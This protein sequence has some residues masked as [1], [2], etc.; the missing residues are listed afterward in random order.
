MKIRVNQLEEQLG[1]K[2]FPA[3]ILSGEEPF[4]K[5]EASQKIRSY[6]RKAGFAERLVYH[7]DASFKWG[8][9][10]ESASA[11]SLFSDRSLI[12]VR[13]PA[14]YNFL[15]DAESALSFYAKHL[16]ENNILLIMMD[17]L[18][19]TIERRT[20]FRQLE[21]QG[22][23]MP[24]WKIEGRYLI[25]WLVE[26]FRSAGLHAGREAITMLAERVEGNLLAAAQE[27]EKLQLLA[28]D[29]KVTMAHIK[30]LVHDS[31]H[32]DIF[33]LA[34]AMVAGEAHH[35]VHIYHGL[36]AEG[37]NELSKILWVIA[38][39][40]RVTAH[41]SKLLAVQVK[42]DAAM[43]IIASEQ[44]IPFFALKRR[45]HQYLGCVNRLGE[46][47]IQRLIVL[48]ADIDA[49]L[50]VN[51]ERES[52]DKLLTLILYAAGVEMIF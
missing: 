44:K 16:P 6:A 36:C 43:Q 25:N 49:Q 32:Y 19:K 14:G 22:V 40:L 39:E 5:E 35:A 3:Y 12:E 37:S 23:W 41:L 7:V 42:L 50:K 31:S 11:L 20:W 15:N 17:K 1:K 30:E 47:E 18:S 52:I 48:A 13:L 10:E 24:I 46:Y 4:Q 45:S 8:L 38:R 2:L 28:P 9:I 29:G 34:E 51:R 33:S 21:S 27:I 26:R